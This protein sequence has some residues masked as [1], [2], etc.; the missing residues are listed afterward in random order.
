MHSGTG[1]PG[2]RRRSLRYRPPR[3]SLPL[4]CL[5]RC[6]KT[7]APP[8]QGGNGRQT[9]AHREAE[10]AGALRLPLGR[11]PTRRLARLLLHPRHLRQ[12]QTVGGNTGYRRP[13]GGREWQA[14]LC[15]RLGHHQSDGMGERQKTAT[16][17]TRRPR[18]LRDAPPRLLHRPQHQPRPRHDCETC[19]FGASGQIPRPHRALGHRPPEGARGERRAHSALLRLRFGRRDTPHRQQVQLGLRPGELQRARGQLL[20]RPLR[21]RLPHPRV[22]ADGAGPAPRRHPCHPRCG[23]QPY[24]R[25]RTL[26]LSAHLARLL[27]PQEC[28]RQLQQRLR[29]RQRD[30]L[31]PAS[32]AAIHDRIG[33]ILDQ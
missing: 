8:L 15:A 12:P 29:L 14:R 28:R 32:D 2:G 1:S 22:Q 4:R 20:Y 23:V 19:Q 31:R 7:G 13:G 11:H 26:Q 21:P 24:L 6:K 33:E 16:A 27:L 17:V 5:A 25:H 18:H 30:G 9:R 3:D 10:T